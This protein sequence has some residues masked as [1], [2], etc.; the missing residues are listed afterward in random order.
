M[1]SNNIN[2][3]LTAVIF[4]I[5]P[6]VALQ[7]VDNSTFYSFKIFMIARKAKHLTASLSLFSYDLFIWCNFSARID[8]ILKF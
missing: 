7:I 3:D 4:L 6:K 5:N 1:R 2:F 8:S